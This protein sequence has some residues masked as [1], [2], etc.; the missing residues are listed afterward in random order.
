MRAMRW[1]P[2]RLTARRSSH[3]P[4][5]KSWRR[6]Y[7]ARPARQADPKREGKASNGEW[8]SKTDPEARIMQH[9]DGHTHLSY[10]VDATVDLETG[11]IVSAGAELANVSD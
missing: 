5:S 7:S 3:R 1:E 4:T 9:A 8:E 2:F 10:K 11:V 6:P